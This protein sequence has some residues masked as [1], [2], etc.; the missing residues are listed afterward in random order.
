MYHFL[1]SIHNKSAAESKTIKYYIHYFH[2][3]YNK[4]LFVY[5]PPPTP[6]PP[7]QKNLLNHCFLFLLC[8]TAVPRESKNNGYAKFWEV[9]EV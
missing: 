6:L 5:P 7:P 4:I 3:A 8:I 2:I 1:P 9:D